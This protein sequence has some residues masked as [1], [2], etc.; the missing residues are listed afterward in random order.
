MNGRKLKFIMWGA[1]VLMTFGAYLVHY[2]GIM[3][4][5]RNDWAHVLLY[6]FLGL[7]LSFILAPLL[8]ELGHL[9]M[10]LISGFKLVSFNISF[11]KFTFYKKFKI[12]I[13]NP[14]V[15]GETVFLPKTPNKYPEKL[16]ATTIAGLVSSVIYM[17]FGMSIVFL[18]T[19]LD[20]VLLFGIPYHVSAYL[21]I[22]NVLP[23]KSD[24]D[25]ALLFS[26]S[27]KG[28]VYN[29][30]VSNVLYASAEIM[31]GVEPKD[32]SARYLTE[33][34]VSYDYYSVMLKYLRYIAFLWHDEES[35]YKELFD[36]SDLSKLPDSLYEIIYKE[37]FFVSVVRGDV[38]F[39]KA[40]EETVIGYL[41]DDNPSNY[42]IHATYRMYKGDDEW[43]KI[44]IESGLKN[45]NGDDG[46][47]KYERRLLSAMKNDN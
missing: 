1:V 20:L 40:N 44:L 8:H 5:Y 10:G 12:S 36:I 14:Y 38:G 21:L 7:L 37:L 18:S 34:Y 13:V 15:F 3:Y 46:L 45:L 27:L 2:I 39:I 31:C 32:V 11:I 29:E 47:S 17:L 24:S 43:A 26:Y 19:N 33:F 30:M 9:I 42:R 41:D 23:F 16:K 4:L 35:A 28:N 22:L 25:G 6:A